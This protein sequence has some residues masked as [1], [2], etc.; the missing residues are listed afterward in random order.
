LLT[1]DFNA[2][3]G[4]NDFAKLGK[5]NTWNFASR[6]DF[7]SD[8]CGNLQGSSAGELFPP[9]ISDNNQVISI[10]SPE[11]CRN[12][13]LDFETDTEVNGLTGKKYSGGERTVDK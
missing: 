11:M 9:H 3:T 8:T 4:E 12:V 6:T 7:F 10:F 2:Y 13:L 1:G 5:L